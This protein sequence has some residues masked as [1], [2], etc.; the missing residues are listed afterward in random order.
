MKVE[1]LRSLGL[2]HDTLRVGEQF[3]TA[4]LP[5]WAPAKYFETLVENGTAMKVDKFDPRKYRKLAEMP[6]KP[7]P[8]RKQAHRGTRGG[9]NQ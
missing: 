2:A 6:E 1:I 3:D 8:S 5:K 9:K 4:E 7:K